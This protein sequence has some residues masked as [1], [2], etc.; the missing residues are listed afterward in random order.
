MSTGVKALIAGAAILG[1]VVLIAVFALVYFKTTPTI[2]V[3]TPPGWEKADQEATE[4]MEE[5]LSQGGQ[6]V[7][8]DYLFTDGTLTN[9]VAIAHGRAYIMDNPDSESFE[10]VE[11]FFMEHQ[12]EFE[13][14]MKSAYVAEGLSTN[15]TEYRVGEMASGITS[16]YV[17]QSVSGQGVTVY[18][19]FMFFF[20]D[21]TMFFAAVGA[22]STEGN[23]EVIDFLTENISFE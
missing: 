4:D 21:D 11:A 13:S 19:D 16:C 10:D 12:G 1:I 5:L 7:D 2:K 8:V 18:L 9:S 14:E 15:I 3:S 23:Q 6:D 22:G 20:K 17:S